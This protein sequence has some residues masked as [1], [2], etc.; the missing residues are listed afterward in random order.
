MTLSL[1]WRTFALLSLLLGGGVFAWVQTL[2]S[3]E[4]EPR[5]IKEASQVAALVNLTRAALG[6]VDGIARVTLLKSLGQV[7]LLHIRP[8]EPSDRS[9]PVA[10][11]R[12]HRELAQEI[13]RQ[14][15]PQARLSPAVNGVPGLWLR[16]TVGSDALW[17]H[18][19]DAE[20]LRFAQSTVLIWMAIALVATVAASAAIAGLINRPLRQMGVALQHV[21]EG[22][23]N[24]RLPEDSATR[25]IRDLNQ[26]FNQ[27]VH[28]LQQADEERTLMLAGISH[29][30]RTPLSRLRLEVELSVAD[31]EVR[32]HMAQDIEQAQNTLGQFMAYAR[33]QA[34]Q[35]VELKP[36]PFEAW[37]QEVLE[38]YR[39]RPDMTVTCCVPADVQVYAEPVGLERSLVNVLE[40]AIRYGKTPQTDISE[41]SIQGWSEEEWFECVIRDQGPGV[42]EEA[43]GRLTQPFYR[44]NTSRT[45][46][47][48][49]GLGLA[50]V[51][52]T[53]AHMGGQLSVANPPQG[54]LSVHLKLRR[55]R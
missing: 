45:D 48:G 50:I 31:P 3:L 1:F 44:V 19:E 9:D 26:G 41:I 40:N 38:P 28:R 53:I 25:E 24:H 29:D 4:L 55:V 47:H 43:L 52:R 16:F 51:E 2:T 23:W 42:P 8:L 21:M 33:P 37:L 17:L 30:L 22:R 18:L 27:M 12:F 46:A 54:G 14:L 36:L 35:S 7:G 32:R 6:Q 10:Q 39:C 11:D 34:P 49:A 5:A 20:S 15:G 13:E